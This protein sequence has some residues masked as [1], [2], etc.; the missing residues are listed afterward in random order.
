MLHW[1]DIKFG[2][3]YQSEHGEARLV[4]SVSAT[5]GK[6]P[7]VIWRTTSASLQATQKAHGS[8]TV[9][10]FLK[11]AVFFT[12]AT[13]ED[14]DAFASATRMRELRNADKR[15]IARYRRAASK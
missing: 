6:Q 10:S 4:T 14:W 1:D 8:C 11:W 13:K 15:A 12:P 2:N 7:V 3:V 9:N 5:S